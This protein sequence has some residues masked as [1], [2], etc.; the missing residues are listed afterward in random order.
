MIVAAAVRYKPAL[1]P[2]ATPLVI[3]VPA[4]ARHSDILHALWQIN[5]GA[6]SDCE[7]GFINDRGEFMNRTDAFVHAIA[8]DQKF[9]ERSTRWEG[10]HELYSEDLW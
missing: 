3:F 6:H 1:L 10:L 9:T 4:P 2:D 7:Q 5:R 8:C